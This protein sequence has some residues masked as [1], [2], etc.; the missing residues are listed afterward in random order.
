MIE[1]PKVA[2][3][4]IS[5]LIGLLLIVFGVMKIVA[6]GVFRESMAKEGMHH[7][8]DWIIVIGVG[9][10]ASAVLFLIP[11]T[12]PLGTLL[13]S[14]FFGGAIMAHMAKGE[15][16]VPQSVFLILIWLAGYL[17]GTW[18]WGQRKE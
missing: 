18:G 13:L 17:R 1:W 12:S 10:V 15:S 3:W 5:L 14:S 6:A 8:A 9:E 7:V 4:V 16:F 11:F 2:G